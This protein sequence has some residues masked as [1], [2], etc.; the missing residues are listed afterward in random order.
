MLHLFIAFYVFSLLSGAALFFSLSNDK[1][2]NTATGFKHFNVLYG[3]ITLCLVVSTLWLYALVNLSDG[4]TTTELFSKIYVNFILL[5]L[6]V[7]PLLIGRY[8]NT[9][10]Q[11]NWSTSQK[12]LLLVTLGYGL[13]AIMGLWNVDQ[14]WTLLIVGI[15]IACLLANIILQEWFIVRNGKSQDNDGRTHSRVMMLQSIGLPIVEVYFLPHFISTSGVTFSLPLVYCINNWLMWKHRSRILKNQN[16]IPHTS[17]IDAILSPK[18]REIAQAIAKGLSNKQIA[19]DFAISPSTVKNHIYN[20]FQ[21]CGV[22][23]RVRL[24]GLLNGK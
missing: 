9:I 7:L 23:N 21:K 13:I 19:A 24:V 17:S 16:S 5:F 8:H 14:D 2:I 12:F 18:E 11:L 3:L 22:H 15:S 4:P 10:Y 1:K 20:I 6:A